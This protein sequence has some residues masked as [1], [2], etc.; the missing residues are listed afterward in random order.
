[1]ALTTARLCSSPT[2]WRAFYTFRLR[3]ADGQGASDTDTATVE[4]RPG[5]R[6]ASGP[7]FVGLACERGWAGRGLPLGLFAGGSGTQCGRPGPPVAFSTCGH[8]P[9]NRT[10]LWTL[11]ENW[12]D[13]KTSWSLWFPT[14][15]KR[16]FKDKRP[17]EVDMRASLLGAPG[18]S[19]SR[20]GHT[21]PWHELG[22]AHSPQGLSYL[23]VS[24]G[25]V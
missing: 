17:R 5:V 12:A 8:L 6:W 21:E 10:S 7:A 2:W 1:M 18:G 15:D 19:S 25:S 20:G 23:T 9:P 16:S 24:G 22:S 3:V 13:S 14:E 11:R 4:V